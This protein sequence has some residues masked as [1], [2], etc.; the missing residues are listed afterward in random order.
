MVWKKNIVKLVSS[1]HCFILLFL[2]RVIFLCC[3]LHGY[4]GDLT[5]YLKNHISQSSSSFATWTT[6]NRSCL[7]PE[8]FIYNSIFQWIEWWFPIFIWK[9]WDITLAILEKSPVVFLRVP[10]IS[11]SFSIEAWSPAGNKLGQFRLETTQ[12][13]PNHENHERE[14]VSGVDFLSPNIS[15]T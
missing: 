6:K 7:E 2:R 4:F 10:G 11:V 9:W 15:G 3:M 14:T 12:I 1:T 13:N 5:G 8:T